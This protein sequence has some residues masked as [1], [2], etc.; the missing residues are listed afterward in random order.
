MYYLCGTI[1]KCMDKYSQK[2][3][4]LFNEMEKLVEQKKKFEEILRNLVV[5]DIVYESGSYDDMFPQTI[6]EIDMENLK[7]YTYEESIKKYQWVTSF[8]LFDEDSKR[9]VPYY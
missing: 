1:K 9:F 4:E 6:I 2:I 3:T 7:L 8:Y 5:G